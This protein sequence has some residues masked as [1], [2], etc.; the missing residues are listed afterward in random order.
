ME[1]KIFCDI[2]KCVGCKSCELAC[3][4]EHSKT[5]NLFSAITEK[6]KPKK[7]VKVSGVDSSIVSIH[8]QHCDEAP[9]I[10]ACMSGALTKDKK[11]GAT[12]HNKDKCV[13]CWMCVMVCPFGAIARDIED[14][15]AVKCD[16]CPD[17]DGFAC[18]DACPTGALFYGTLEEFKKHLTKDKTEVG[19][20]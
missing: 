10:T 12:I 20:R 1:K 18:V 8:C 14:H 17:R 4:I 19:H 11:T 7:R 16:L 15:I 2:R 5:K 13:G 6:P 3:A 9:C